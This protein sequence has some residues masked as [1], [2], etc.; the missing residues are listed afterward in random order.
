MSLTRHRGFLKLWAAQALSA[1]GS[2]ITRTALPIIAITILDASPV[3]LAWLAALSVVPGVL[4]SALAGGYVDRSSK[5][6]LLIGADL[7]RAVLVASI[8]VAWA[9]GFLG[10]PQLL[11]VATCVGTATILFQIADNSFLPELI[12]RDALVEGNARLETTDA[13]AEISGPAAAGLLIPVLAAP[14]AVIVDAISYLWSASLL[15]TIRPQELARPA[16]HLPVPPPV[17]LLADAAEGWRITLGHPLVRPTL[18]VEAISAFAVGPFMTLYMLF[19]L[20]D[21]GLAAATVGLVI[22]AGGVGALLGAAAAN[23]FGD[24]G[25]FGSRMAWALALGQAAALCVPLAGGPS[26][27]A[28]SALLVQQV[29]GDGLLVFYGI[30]AVS[31]RQTV[32]PMATLGRG[33]AA[34]TLLRAV[35]QPAGAL[36]A[37]WLA[38]AIGTRPTLWAGALLGMAAP[39]AL[40]ASRLRRLQSLHDA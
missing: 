20:R 24:V 11:L 28:V 9:S 14:L 23:R 19:A 29:V 2:R 13:L 31:L 30:G 21:L 7:V 6:H 36:T 4:V 18:L 25:G 5:R 3:Q 22:G 17:S 27:L 26:W 16:V 38:G 10:V 1:F 37:G 34:F 33:N 8:P 15:G 32:L 39:V 35:L 40:V 12:G